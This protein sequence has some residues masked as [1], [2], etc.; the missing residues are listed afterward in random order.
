[1]SGPSEGNFLLDRY[2][3]VVDLRSRLTAERLAGHRIGWVGTSGD[4]HEGHLSLVRRAADENDFTVMFWGGSGSFDWAEHEVAHERDF[5][6]DVQMAIAAGLDAVF[7]PDPSALFPAAPLTQ[8]SVPTMSRDIPAL[9]DPAHLDLI[10]TVMAKLFNI[11]GESRTYSGEKDWQQ[12]T[13]FTRIAQDLDFPVEVVGCPTIREEDGVAISSRNARLT[14]VERAAAPALYEALC[15]VRAAIEGGERSAAEL[16][17]LA[18]ERIE[19]D[20][21]LVYFATVRADDLSLVDPVAGDIR[22]LASMGFESIRLVDNIGV[23]V[24]SS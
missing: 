20:A 22:I 10:A 24:E 5:A 9:E 4:L 12:L 23:T 1:M 8:V 6:R 7:A 19:Q 17:K 3:D 2:T 14:S 11:F 16:E 21:Q 13:M 18:R 15:A